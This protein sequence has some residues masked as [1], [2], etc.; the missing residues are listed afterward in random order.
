MK[1]LIVEDEE[2]LARALAE[3]FGKS[4]FDTAIAHTGNTA[5]KMAG[6]YKPDVILLD[7][8]LPGKSGI[9]VLR[10][11]KAI[12]KLAKTPVV[13]LSNFSQEIDIKHALEIG[14]RDYIIK[15][16]YPLSQLVERIKTIVSVKQNLI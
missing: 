4:G 15:T 3:K 8:L 11:L 14:A 1:I 6:E 7:I 5:L 2:M 12:K 10:R 16:Q 13:I 9:Q